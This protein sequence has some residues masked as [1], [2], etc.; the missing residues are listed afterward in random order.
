ML[1]NLEKQHQFTAEM[2]KA[3]PQTQAYNRRESLEC[4]KEE[5][6]FLLC[7]KPNFQRKI[8]HTNLVLNAKSVSEIL[9]VKF[10]R[11]V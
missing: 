3:S 10:Q 8:C 1:T 7:F 2:M 9:T 11:K 5:P 4:I 6:E